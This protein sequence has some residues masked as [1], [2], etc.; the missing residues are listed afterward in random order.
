MVF[1][2]SS[3]RSSLA[4]S[5]YAHAENEPP[6]PA[7]SRSSSNASN[8]SRW[9]RKT[10]NSKVGSSTG[11]PTMLSDVAADNVHRD[12]WAGHSGHLSS[13]QDAKLQAFKEALAAKGIYNESGE[14]EL[15]GGKGK[16]KIED[17]SLL[18]FLRARKFDVQGAVKQYEE[19]IAWRQDKH[20][21]EKYAEYDIE[22]FERLRAVY[23]MWTGRRDTRGMPIYV[24]KI[25]SLT[26][27]KLNQLIP[28][29]EASSS[30]I[31]IVT[32]ALI[33]FLLP[34]C[35][36][37][38]RQNEEV[39]IA[40]TSSIVDVGDVGLSRFWGLRSH[41]QVASQVASA[42]FPETIDRV[43]VVGAPSFFPTVFNWAK[44]WFDQGTVDKIHI[45]G[46]SPLNELLRWMPRSSIP[47]EY[48]GDLG[49]TY[50]DSPVL[51]EE[52]SQAF[53]VK[54]WVRGPI[55]WNSNGL[56]HLGTVNGQPR[57]QESSSSPSRAQP[58]QSVLDKGAM[59]S[60][61]PVTYADGPTPKP[62]HAKLPSGAPP[63]DLQ[64]S[65]KSNSDFGSIFGNS[66]VP[67]TNDQEPVMAAHNTPQSPSNAMHNTNVHPRLPNGTNP[68]ADPV[69]KASTSYV[70]H[71]HQPVVGG[72]EQRERRESEGPIGEGNINHKAKQAQDAIK[73]GWIPGSGV[74]EEDFL[75]SFKQ[76]VV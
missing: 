16:G 15:A 60:A 58:Q 9:S 59:L 7:L 26:T 12:P 38:P 70:P 33:R 30:S 37:L 54:G 18:R 21:D 5:E 8:L 68:D 34:F 22:E 4:T 29:D 53:G 55:A 40:G 25:S 63:V 31:A 17:V 66:P 50:G 41:L 65:S 28:N 62:T 76:V 52:A 48:G 24:Y 23:P 27:A 44:K 46:T 45:L 56:V 20:I 75:N 19:Y 10:T 61:E 6:S 1:G 73:A 67:S 36:T 3:R 43:F 42:N 57:Q 71:T 2:S 14:H 49:W 69:P 39:P 35:S 72:A 11:T 13:A 47:T 51:D 64:N 32:F 74:T